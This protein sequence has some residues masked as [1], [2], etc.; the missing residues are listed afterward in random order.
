MMGNPSKTSNVCRN[1]RHA[2]LRGHFAPGQRL[3]PAT[4]ADEFATSLMPIR[5]A[6]HGLASERLINHHERGYYMP[7]PTEAAL[8]GLYDWM[9]ERLLACLDNGAA[10]DT[11]PYTRPA[12]NDDTAVATWQLFDT[13]ARK[14]R[15]P[16]RRH[17]AQHANDRLSP[18]RVAKRSLFP[19]AHAELD[20]LISAW[21][22][23]K[24]APLK[25]YLR[26]YHARRRPRVPAIV[27]LLNEARGMAH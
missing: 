10:P 16:E 14:T 13:I 26:T 7:L 23:A 18:I 11:K 2:V 24:I 9:E 22:G 20:E 5:F 3:E 25:R 15:Y 21:E 19:D 27:E 8:R 4:L 17:A 1:I 6:L 12:P